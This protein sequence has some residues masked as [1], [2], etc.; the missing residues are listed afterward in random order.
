MAAFALEEIG[1]YDGDPNHLLSEINM[2]HSFVYV[3]NLILDT[4]AKL[5]AEQIRNGGS[6]LF[7]DS[8]KIA[9]SRASVLTAH[10]AERRKIEA[11]EAPV[12]KQSDSYDLSALAL[13]FY[14]F[15]MIRALGLGLNA[16]DS[17]YEQLNKSLQAADLSVN[18]TDNLSELQAF[19]ASFSESLRA[20]VY[21]KIEL[22]QG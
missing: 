1:G 18:E 11:C 3:R 5:L 17:G 12:F 10:L 16:V 7:L 6:T 22:S 8:E 19:K 21:Q 14:G 9:D 20:Y 15:E 13:T 2:E 4:A